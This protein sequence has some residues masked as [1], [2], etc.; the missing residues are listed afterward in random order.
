MTDTTATPTDAEL[1]AATRDGCRRSFGV[2]VDRYKD[3][4][5]GYLTRLTGSPERAEDLAQEAF[6]RLYQ[7]ADG[8]DERGRL[9]GYLYTIAG[10]LLRSQERRRRVWNTLLP[11]LAP[12]TTSNGF[13]LEE[14]AGERRV[15]QRELGRELARALAELPLHYRVPLV[16]YEIE[17]WSY[18]DI[19]EHVGCRPGTV[20]SRLHR[21]RQ[22]LQ[23]A[24]AP[25]WNEG[26]D[27]RTK[28]T[29]HG[30]TTAQ[31]E[32]ATPA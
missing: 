15:L 16:L 4:L 18:D 27:A 25:Y 20:K 11:F 29:G 22:R 13:H 24:L 23:K 7:N 6:L 8:Y 2:L 5:V 31:R 12:P 9:Q 14:A 26:Q 28:D 32:P 3:P 10:N 1:M 21:A 30:R 19:A 17:E